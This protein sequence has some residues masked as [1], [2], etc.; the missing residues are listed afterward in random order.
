MTVTTTTAAR[1]AN[2]TVATVRTWCRTGL[3]TAVK[4]G[5]RWAIDIVSLRRAAGL[6]VRVPSDRPRA[7]EN[8]PAKTGRAARTPVGAHMSVRRRHAVLDAHTRRVNRAAG[9][10]TTAEYLTDVVGADAA[11]VKSYAA[12]FGTAVAKVFRAEFGVEPSRSGLVRVG[13][14]LFPVFGYAAGDVEVLTVLDKGARNYRR[15]AE[16]LAA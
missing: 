9:C 3:V 13:R 7:G 5:G 2:V 16:L 12:P 1:I 10:V 6:P 15:T 8:T 4:T 11:F 14:R